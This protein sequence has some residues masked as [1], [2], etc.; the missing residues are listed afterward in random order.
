MDNPL[1]YQM[2]EYDCGPTS[3]L[4]A[5]SYLFRRD[6]IP[7][8]LTRN[9]MLYCLDCFGEDGSTGRRG[10]SRMAMMFLS[11]WLNGY[12]ETGHL[13]VSSR[14]LSGREVNFSQNGPLRDAL[15]RGGAAV[16]RLDLEGWHYVLLT[17]VE[18]GDV[19]LFDPYY[20]EGPFDNAELR[21]IDEHPC[22]YNR[23]VPVHYFEREEISVYS[24]GPFD[25]GE[26]ILLF[27]TDTVLTE[28]KTVEYFI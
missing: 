9:I 18:G 4:N 14:Y 13:A 24:L 10:T 23:I 1:R 16:V 3:M 21:V 15:R 20:H 26:A 5:V 11:N 28:D 17:R 7:P 2:T 27:N 8:E 22:S 19:Y 25:T 6:E 12:G